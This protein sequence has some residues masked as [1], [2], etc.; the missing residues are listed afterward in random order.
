RFDNAYLARVPEADMLV[1]ESYEYWDGTGWALNDEAAAAPVIDVPVAELSVAYNSYYDKYMM[2]YL[3]ENRYAIVMR[4]SDS[5]TSG[6]SAETEIATGA[7]YPGLYGAFIHP[8]TNDGRD[9]YFL[10]SE[11]APYNVVLMHS[12]LDIGDPAENLIEDPS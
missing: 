10:M 9:L 6:W 2:T 5:L 12:T 8:W 3:N 4:S 11:W 1:K 7:E